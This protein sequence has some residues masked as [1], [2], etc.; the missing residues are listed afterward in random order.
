MSWR[1]DLRR[2]DFAG[3]ELIGASFRGVPFFVENAQ[4]SGGRRVVVHEFPLRDVPFVEDLGRRSRTFPIEGYVIGDDYLVQ[5][6]ALLSALEDTAGPGELRHPNY[7]VL[8]A[9]CSS[10]SVRES[11]A[12]G[13]MATFSIEFV[14]TPAQA[15]VPT[16]EDDSAGVVAAGADTAVTAAKA[17]LL[18]IYDTD[19]LPAFSLDTAEAA[20]TG[21][22]D[23]VAD[24]LGPLATETEELATFTGRINLIKSR[25]ASL[26]RKPADMFDDFQEAIT[27]LVDTVASVPGA[28]VDALIESYG[29]DLGAPAP[30]GTS[31]RRREQANQLA[32]QGAL[33]RT[34]A[35][36]AARI[37]PTVPYVSIEEA[38]AARDHVAAMLE[39]QA[40]AAG[41]T[42]YP[43]LVDLR[44]RVLR[45]VPGSKG[46]ASVVTVTRPIATPSL[47]LAY[48]LYGSV[49]LEADIIA[50]NKVRH[51]GFLSGPIKVLSDA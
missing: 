46:L 11:R 44:S 22:S 35:I 50:R 1:E 12:E 48:Q 29:V 36:E 32:L 2:V 13:G 34:M 51:P 40:G 20:L 7:G 27:G 33:R 6:N 16:V 24:K 38:T 10:L 41:D 3:R 28:V 45:A 43:G 37:L 42:A 5:K 18:E 9:V 8:R 14:E 15:P 19:G 30:D 49:D 47:L 4:R 39:E 17:E 26:V 31:T 21:A 23:A 25:A